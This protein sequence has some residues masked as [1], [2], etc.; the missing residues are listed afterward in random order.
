MFLFPRL[1]AVLANSSLPGTC[2]HNHDAPADACSPAATTGEV[3]EAFPATCACPSHGNPSVRLTHVDL[4]NATMVSGNRRV[5][6]A[7]MCFHQF[8]KVLGMEVE[9]RAVEV[10]PELFR[11]DMVEVY[12]GEEVVVCSCWSM[13]AFPDS[14]V[15][16]FNLRDA[17]LQVQNWK[18]STNSGVPVRFVV[19]TLGCDATS[20]DAVLWVPYLTHGVMQHMKLS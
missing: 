5:E 6:L 20:G 7:Q 18:H 9:Y 3:Q 17:V 10:L 13:M 19:I 4:S 15:V 16:R 1:A 12:P 14:S 2:C 11:P 8:G